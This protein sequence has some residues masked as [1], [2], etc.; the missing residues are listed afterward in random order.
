MPTKVIVTIVEACF[1]CKYFT[2]I[3]DGSCFCG[4]TLRTIVFRGAIPDWCPLD[5]Q[6]GGE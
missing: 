5:D 4:Q 2:T 6:D 3:F 1:E